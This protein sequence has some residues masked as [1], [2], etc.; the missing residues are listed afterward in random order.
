MPIRENMR[1]ITPR[2]DIGSE[3]EMVSCYLLFDP[4]HADDRNYLILLIATSYDT[5]PYLS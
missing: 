4:R 3:M 2:P 1:I 5:S